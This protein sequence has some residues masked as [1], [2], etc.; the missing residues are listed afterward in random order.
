[1]RAQWS[2]GFGGGLLIANPIPA[3]DEIAAPVID[4]AITQALTEME[5]TGHRRQGGHALSAGQGGGDHRRRQPEGQ[6]GADPQQCPPRGRNR[7]G[8]CG[9][10]R[11][12]TKPPIK[13]NKAVRRASIC[14]RLPARKTSRFSYSSATGASDELFASLRP[15]SDRW[16]SASPAAAKIERSSTESQPVVTSFASGSVDTVTVDVLDPEAA[17]Q[18]ELVAPDGTVITAF[19]V[20]R[21]KVTGN[22]GGGQPHHGRR[23]RGR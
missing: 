18:I 22:Y 13:R 9:A 20:D 14:G 12:L 4:Q 3:A 10:L 17:D 2:P 15:R 23:G 1:M 8:L 6:H 19:R 21:E 16:R 11:R 5:N 7:R